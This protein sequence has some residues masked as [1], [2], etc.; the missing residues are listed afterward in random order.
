[1]RLCD[2]LVGMRIACLL[3]LHDTFVQAKWLIDAIYT[4]DDYYLEAV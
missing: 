3:M 2:R 4:S 1:V